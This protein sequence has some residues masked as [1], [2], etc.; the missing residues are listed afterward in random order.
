MKSHGLTTQRYPGVKALY[1]RAVFGLSSVFLGVICLLWHD[2]DTWQG[3]VRIVTMPWGWLVGDAL[4]IALIVAGFALIVPATARAASAAL[5]ILFTIFALA[6]LTNVVAAPA[7]VD[8]YYGVSEQLSLICGALATFAFVPA[9]IGMGL[10]AL[11]FALGQIVFFQPT[12]ALVPPWIPPSREF[13]AILTTAAFVVAGIAMLTSIKA[14]LSMRLMGAMVALFGVLVWVPT[15][16]AHV[17]SHND[18][19]EFAFTMLIAGAS[20]TAA[21]S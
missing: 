8:S 12:V 13:W 19:S 6:C 16:A 14:R 1:A 18:W 10:A 3:L 7:S 11:Y 9:R 4:M 2:A 5:A 20:L 15:V 17:Q 21:E